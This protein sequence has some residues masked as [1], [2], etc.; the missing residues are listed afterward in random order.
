MYAPVAARF[1]TWQ[2]ELPADALA[3]VEALWAHRWMR[4][5]VADAERETWINEIYENPAA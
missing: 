1:W 2:P 3:Y 5:W 4:E